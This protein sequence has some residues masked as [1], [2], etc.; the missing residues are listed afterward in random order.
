[1]TAITGI[2][3]EKISASESRHLQQL[4]S[5]L[6]KRIIGQAEAVATIASAI[7]RARTGLKDENRPCGVFMFVGATGVGKTLLAKELSQW[8][9]GNNNALIRL[10]M[11]EYSQ[12]HTVS[13]LFGAPPGYVGYGQGGELTEAVRR[14]PYSVVLFDEI[15]KAHP[16]LFNTLLQV[17]DEGYIT[18]S[19]GRKVDFKSTIIIMTSNVGS[20]TNIRQREIGYITNSADKTPMTESFHRALERH[21]A[22]E[23]LNRID[24]IVLFNELSTTEAQQIVNLEL[25]A[26]ISRLKKIGYNLHITPQAQEYIVKNGFD[27]KYG[28]RSIKRTITRLIEHPISQMIVDNSISKHLNI[29]ISCKDNR[30]SISQ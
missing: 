8:Y 26:I 22:P 5:L 18:D 10:D 3:T 7:R 2:P 13:R 23:F 25:N 15:E 24:E 12:P 19:E 6:S 11:S 14:R 30:L 1:V 21:F 16:T 28:A 29:T 27:K 4:E 9:S 17:L 20:A